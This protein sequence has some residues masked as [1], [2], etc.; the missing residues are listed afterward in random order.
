MTKLVTYRSGIVSL[1]GLLWDR[2]VDALGDNSVAWEGEEESVREEHAEL[3]EELE[4]LDHY[5]T[6]HG[7]GKTDTLPDSV[8]P[9]AELAA[10][11]A[12]IR[13][14]E[15]S[16]DR[17]CEEGYWDD[18]E[19]AS[20][21]GANQARSEAAALIRTA[22]KA[23]GIDPPA[24]FEVCSDCYRQLDDH[25][26][27]CRLPDAEVEFTDAQPDPLRALEPSE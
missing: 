6:A 2:I 17:P 10:I 24:G 27:Q 11:K 14:A 16:P 1:P 25:S 20:A 18:M 15:D 19:S 22:L 4:S 9:L 13:F 3:I 7:G 26:S 5:L 12:L 8:P 23:L 21:D